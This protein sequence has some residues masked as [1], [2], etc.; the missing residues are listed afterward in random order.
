[1]RLTARTVLFGLAAILGVR[2]L[3]MAVIPFADTSEPRYAEI[4]R[5]MAASG[6]W[7]TPWFA[8]GEPFWGKPPLAF[9]AQ[10]V[11]GAWLGMGELSLRLPSWLAMLGVLAILHELGRRLYTVQAARWAVLVFSTMLLPLVAA[12]AVLTDPFLALGVTLGMASFILAPAARSWF[13]RYGL[14]IGLAIG[15]LSKGPLAAVLMAGAIVPWLLWHGNAARHLRALPWVG[16]TALLS[17]LTLPWY[18]LAEWKTP[19]FLQYF[20]VGEHVLRFIDPGW[21]GDRYGSAHSRP[22]GAIWLDWAMAALPWSPVGLWLLLRQGRG[23]ALAARMRAFGRS[24]P[25]TYLFAWAVATP[26]F[27]TLSGNILWTYVL[28]ALPPVALGIGAGLSRL[29]GIAPRRVA[30]ACLMLVPAVA[31]VLGI[32]SFAQPDRFKTEKQ[33]IARADAEIRAG[34]KLYFVDSMPFSARFYSRGS[35]VAVSRGDLADVL[36]SQ[37]GRVLLAVEKRDL[38]DIRARISGTVTPLYT[39]RRYVLLDVLAPEKH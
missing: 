19:G 3:A 21:T 26:A 9:W 12:G 15:F 7:I 28:P 37:G 17:G 10:A 33:L 6:D 5:V 22:Y 39:S 16:G 4:A 11:S 27:F 18:L 35:A 34:E 30:L 25:S 32:L 36:P 31:I 38:A 29:D 8:P 23:G 20:V 24:V 14:F 13:W 1:M 2:L